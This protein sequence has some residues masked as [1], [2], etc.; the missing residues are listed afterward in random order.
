MYIVLVYF[1]NPKRKPDSTK[2][3]LLTNSVRLTDTYC[4]FHD[5]FN[6]DSRSDIVS[7]KKYT[8]LRHYKLILTSCNYLYIVPPP[9]TTHTTTKS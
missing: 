7:A 1:S 6:F 3:I 8:N 2:Y 4:F 5:L 9:I